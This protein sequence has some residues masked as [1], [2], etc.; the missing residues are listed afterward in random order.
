[1]NSLTAPYPR[2]Q[3]GWFI[4]FCVATRHSLEDF[5]AQR[6]NAYFVI[7]WSSFS[8]ERRLLLSFLPGMAKNQPLPGESETQ[9]LPQYLVPWVCNQGL[10]HINILLRKNYSCISSSAG[11]G[12]LRP[13]GHMRSANNLYQAKTTLPLFSFSNRFIPYKR[14]INM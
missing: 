3:L 12:K 10:P 11:A 1:M 5:R 13:A 2:F 8:M 14:I 9:D 7:P 6:T 4:L